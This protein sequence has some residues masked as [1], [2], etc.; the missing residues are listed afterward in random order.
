MC[1]LQSVV[2]ERLTKMSQRMYIHYIVYSIVFLTIYAQDNLES[3]VEII[4]GKEPSGKMLMPF[5]RPYSYPLI[6]QP[7][8]VCKKKN[9]THA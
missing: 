7:V 3:E 5:H 1:N 6:V 9:V 2:H 8:N 4:T